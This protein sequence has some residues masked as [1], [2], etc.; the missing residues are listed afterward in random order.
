MVCVD[1][2]KNPLVK[3]RV[4]DVNQVFVN[5]H[6]HYNV[7]SGLNT[8]AFTV[9]PSLKR[10]KA[11]LQKQLVLNGSEFLHQRLF[12]IDSS[13]IYIEGLINELEKG[14]MS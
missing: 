14:D 1:Q 12:G 13:I 4:Q 2:I 11:E 9:L 3:Q 5:Y 8:L 6:N 7:T 10:E